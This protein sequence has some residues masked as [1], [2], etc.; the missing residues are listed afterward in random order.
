[1][2]YLFVSCIQMESCFICI[3]YSRMSVECQTWIFWCY[4]D[5]QAFSVCGFFLTDWVYVVAQRI[6]FW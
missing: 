3:S 6:T 4:C 5:I 1:M 2:F